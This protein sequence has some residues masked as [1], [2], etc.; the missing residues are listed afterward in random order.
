[1]YNK[2]FKMRTK[3]TFDFQVNS[4]FP[5]SAVLF[6]ILIVLLKVCK[7]LSAS[8]WKWLYAFLF[9]KKYISILYTYIFI[10]C[11]QKPRSLKQMTSKWRMLHLSTSC[12]GALWD[13]HVLWQLWSQKK[14]AVWNLNACCCKIRGIL[15]GIVRILIISM[16]FQEVI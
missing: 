11:S 16:V 13:R 4:C 3:F 10:T 5:K 9:K 15:G 2:E 8:L 12:L 1:M 6:S 7:I 14:W